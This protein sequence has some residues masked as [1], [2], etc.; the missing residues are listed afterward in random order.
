MI[1]T[2]F[3]L[4]RYKL[5]DGQ[6][7]NE[8]GVLKKVGESKV[9]AVSGS[10]S[11]V[12]PDGRTYRVDYTAD[13]RGYRAKV[14]YNAQ[15]I[16]SFVQKVEKPRDKVPIPVQKEIVV[17]RIQPQQLTTLKP[18]PTKYSSNEFWLS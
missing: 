1:G 13:E 7:R 8:M 14:D 17:T 11:Y 15:N 6:T 18:R 4:K 3:A 16:P 12:G 10:Y 9:L 2:L 5:S